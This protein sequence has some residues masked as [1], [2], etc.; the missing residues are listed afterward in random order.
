MA[1]YKPTGKGSKH[2][3]RVT[4]QCANCF[5][6]VTTQPSLVR[7]TCS[8]SCAMKMRPKRLTAP[9]VHCKG[10]GVEFSAR[11]CGGQRMVFCTRDCL[12]QHARLVACEIAALRRIGS[13][14]RR[15]AKACER[16][17]DREMRPIKPDPYTCQCKVCGSAFSSNRFG[18]P[19][20]YCSYSC[21]LVGK[22]MVPS[23]A[24]AKSSSARRAA[25][26][27]ARAVRRNRTAGGES[28][29]PFEVMERD[30]WRC[31]LCRVSTPKAKRGSC[32]PDAPEL[33][34]IVP[35]ARGGSHTRQN[36]R[37]LCRKCNSAKSDLL[38]HEY[39]LK[40][41]A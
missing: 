3:T 16:A 41:A 30:N 25:K 36:T 39:A 26:S 22:K 35:L 1:G 11:M 14:Y 18:K 5:K 12:T 7:D 37:C 19:P 21:R 40:I 2:G 24:A 34:H 23:R 20:R 33:D 13:A 4:W 9:I 15:Y 27:R 6:S 10:C 29:D 28:F 8:K 17:R 32:E 31:G 38:D